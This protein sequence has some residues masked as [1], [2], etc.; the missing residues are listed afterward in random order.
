[1]FRRTP[2]CMR[3]A[4]YFAVLTFAVAAAALAPLGA[5]APNGKSPRP[6]SPSAL[7]V[8]ATTGSAV[9]IAWSPSG[10]GKTRGYGVYRDDARVGETTTT[11][12]TV[13]E[14]ACGATY[15]FG[16]DAVDR[17]GARSA[18]A[19]VT[20]STAPC[21][22]AAPP[23]T[24]TN[25]VAAAQTRTSISV[26]WTASVD[27]SGVSGYAVYLN[28]AKLTDTAT[29]SYTVDGVAC[30]TT[31]TIAVDA[32]D[33]A[34]NRSPKATLTV[35]TSSCSDSQ[36]PSVPQSQRI[37]GTTASTIAM[38]W[39]SSTD[40]VGVA[41]YAV[42][43][44]G[45]RVGTT[46]Q[47]TYA[48][49]SLGCGTT[50]TVGLAA[51][52]TAGNYSDPA[53]A[54]GPATTQACAGDTTAP[55]APANLT[56]TSATATSISIS[57][58]ASSDNVGVIGYG[59]YRDG[60]LVASGTGTTY[61]FGGLSCGTSYTLAVDAF[62]A[63]G[64]RSSR[65]TITR[66][67]SACSTPP[68]SGLSIAPGQSWQ[69][70]YN[71][72]ASGSVINVLAGSHGTQRIS[73][74]K[75]VTFL[76]QNGAV[77]RQFWNE[78]SNITLDN[79]DIDGGGQRLTILE[80]H[81]SNNTYRNLEIRNNT[82]VQMVGN[83]GDNATYDNVFFH[84]AVIT[85]A[86]EAAG[87]HM[88]CV[89]SNGP[90]IKVRN[91][92]FK[93]CAIMDLYLTLGT[94]WGQPPYT[95]VVVED[96][97]FYPS[98]RTNNTGTHFYGFLVNGHLPINGWTIRRNRFDNSVGEDESPVSNSTICGNTGAVDADWKIPC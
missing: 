59:R 21:P 84:D 96:S 18:P 47:T 49:A 71:S 6:D 23:T 51:F 62:D 38:A 2:S 24:P 85:T 76:G 63:A 19:I 94:W 56:T 69:T 86:G 83:Y 36:A 28:G 44:N 27:S 60:S 55:T 67:T 13:S 39:A 14:L 45:T 16:V 15:Q 9:S 7:T 98:E 77:M 75:P 30:G 1:M 87:V 74:S 68:P 25:L 40:N 81:G 54:S 93:D 17:F 95:G 91:S 4:Q 53:Y 35:S 43:L 33:A 65:A 90:G 20:A 89:W 34:G 32:Y 78:A 10:S 88:E 70:A 11:S 48:Y 92:I 8:A 46:T 5:S 42:Y 58:S 57:W 97:I 37:T 22:D 80:A 72:A 12:Y 66:A 3:L 79:V 73:G 26:A 64:N 29:T 50:Y 61:T 41:G 52:D 82:D 31:Y